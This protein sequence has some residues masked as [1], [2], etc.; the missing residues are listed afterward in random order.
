MVTKVSLIARYL[1]GLIFLVFGFMGLFNLIPP[2]PDMPE[3]LQ[4]FMG[5]LMATGYFFTL[6]K[7][8]EALS[9]LLLLLG[10]APA[11]VLVVLAPITI[12]IFCVHLFMTPGISN[13]VM[14]SVIVFLHI[15]SAINYWHLYKPLFQKEAVVSV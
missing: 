13:L 7:L 12:N 14:P 10:V 2:P 3:R 15:A 9:G 8:T 1:L 5:G 11:L 4:T 6:L